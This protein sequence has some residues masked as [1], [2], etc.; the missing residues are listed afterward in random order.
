M[1]FA[2]SM[3]SSVSRSRGFTLVELTAVLGLSALLATSVVIALRAM[4]R[5]A[6]LE[7]NLSA[8]AGLDERL[9]LRA[10]RFGRAWEMTIDLDHKEFRW[11]P[12]EGDDESQSLVCSQLVGVLVDGRRNAYGESTV[13][14]DADGRSTPFAVGMVE[15]TMPT[16]WLTFAP[17]TGM[18]A[19]TEGE[20][21]E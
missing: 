11:R 19:R 4:L 21:L 17:Q 3:K 15:T 5:Q 1:G 6:R 7:H 20:P 12:A 9:R 14:Y 8:L 13:R 10:E 2:A 16:V 18:V